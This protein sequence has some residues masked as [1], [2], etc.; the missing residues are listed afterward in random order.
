MIR[1]L[2]VPQFVVQSQK[3]RPKNGP[4]GQNWIFQ[5][6][7]QKFPEMICIQAQLVCIHKG[8]VILDQFK[9]KWSD[10]YKCLNFSSKVK[11]M[12]ENQVGGQ[13]LLFSN[14]FFKNFQKWFA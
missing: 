14:H 11:I 4:I 3:R 8:P 1:P 13:K 12:S 9:I 10:N 6:L 5:S 2:E 7:F